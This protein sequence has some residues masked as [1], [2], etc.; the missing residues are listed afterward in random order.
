MLQKIFGFFWNP[1]KCIMVSTKIISST[2]V[3]KFDNNIHY[4]HITLIIHW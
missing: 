1:E 2:T 3:F 4:Q